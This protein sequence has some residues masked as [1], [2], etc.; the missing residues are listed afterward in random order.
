[1][2]MIGAGACS[3]LN[4]GKLLLRD[5]ESQEEGSDIRQ[6][7]YIQAIIFLILQSPPSSLADV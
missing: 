5:L 2:H 3:V 1:M 7:E 4:F 6:R